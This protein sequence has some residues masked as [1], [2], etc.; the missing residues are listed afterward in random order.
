MANVVVCDTVQMQHG[1]PYAFVYSTGFI[2]VPSVLLF[3]LAYIQN[4]CFI[5]INLF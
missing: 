2:Y 3:F 4:D 1:S 5:F